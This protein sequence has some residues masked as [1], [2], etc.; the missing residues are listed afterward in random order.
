M[1][2]LPTLKFN[3]DDMER[4]GLLKLDVLLLRMLS[5]LEHARRGLP[6]ERGVA[7]AERTARHIFQ[8]ASPRQV[9]MSV[10]L[11]PTCLTDPKSGLTPPTRTQSEGV[12]TSVYG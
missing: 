11:K 12:G 8:I 3:K 2:G 10:Q 6:S 7:R 1:G 9:R 4:L 5:C